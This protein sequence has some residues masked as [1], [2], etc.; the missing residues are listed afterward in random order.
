MKLDL[1]YEVDVRRPWAGAHPYGQRPAERQAFREA[2]EQVRLADRMGFNTSWHV[3]HHFREGRSHSS[4]PEVLIGALSQITE[5]IRLG[6]GVTLLSAGFGSPVRLAE[7]VATADQLSG[8]RVEWGTGR[9]TPMEQSAFGVDAQASKA[10]V[11]EA[12]RFI[13]EAW[14]SEYFSFNGEYFDFPVRKNVP[15]RMVTPKP[16]QDPHPLA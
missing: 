5:R 8:G 15:V 10:Q 1:L 3:E 11:I 6:F 9:S 4:A 14:E 13:V 16:F 2:L 12:I 7:R